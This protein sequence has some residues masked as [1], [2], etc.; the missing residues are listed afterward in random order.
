MVNRSIGVKRAPGRT[1]LS[2]AS[3]LWEWRDCGS[4][5]KS[6]AESWGASSSTIIIV[7]SAGLGERL[8][9]HLRGEL[10]ELPRTDKRLYLEMRF[11]AIKEDVA[12]VRVAALNDGQRQYQRPSRTRVVRGIS[13]LCGGGRFSR[14]E[15]PKRALYVH[16]TVTLFPRARVQG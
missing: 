9:R 8:L 10:G 15:G 14:L 16:V 4:G 2:C 11:P 12:G 5:M 3:A 1:F 6:G 13:S 7:L